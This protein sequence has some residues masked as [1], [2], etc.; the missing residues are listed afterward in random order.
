VSALPTGLHVLGGPRDAE[1]MAAM[2][3]EHYGAL[4]AFL[5][6][7][8]DVLLLDLGTGITGP[9]ARFAI[10]RADQTVVVTTPDWVTASSVLNSLDYIG[11]ADRRTLVLNQVHRGGA[12]GLE[13]ELRRQ[14]LERRVAIPH[15]TRLRGMLDSGTYSLPGLDRGT[16]APVK[17]LTLSAA[18]L[19]V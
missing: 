2:T 16:R 3:P 19:L 17:E 1:A 9:L 14:G 13:A 18:E 7:F 5:G 10:E 6:R 8:Y 15:D 11:D 12:V 4:A